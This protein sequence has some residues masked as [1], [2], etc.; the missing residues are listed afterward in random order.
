MNKKYVVQAFQQNLKGRFDVLFRYYGDALF[1]VPAQIIVSQIKDELGISLSE[2][3][4][5]T[6][7]K[8]IK[9]TKATPSTQQPAAST[10]TLRAQSPPDAPP[11]QDWGTIVENAT[12]QPKQEKNKDLDF[13]DF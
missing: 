8:R 13:T 6:L 12:K 9:R 11:D 3:S 5:Y 10:Q 1:Q 4:I 7:K 2:Q